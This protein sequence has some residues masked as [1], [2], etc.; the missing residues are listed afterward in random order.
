M[1]NMGTQKKEEMVSSSGAVIRE[2]R[3]DDLEQR[4]IQ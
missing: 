4:S 3:V 1:D 2:T